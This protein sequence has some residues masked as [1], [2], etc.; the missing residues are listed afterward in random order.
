MAEAVAAGVLYE[1]AGPKTPSPLSTHPVHHCT[2]PLL[3]VN[4][5]LGAALPS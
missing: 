1:K 2:S 4:I 5:V 3:K